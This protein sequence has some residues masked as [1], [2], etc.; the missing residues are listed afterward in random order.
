LII[1]DE[2][3]KPMKNIICCFAVL[4]SIVSCNQTTN[5]INSLNGRYVPF[6]VG[7]GYAHVLDTQTGRVYYQSGTYNDY[8]EG[9]IPK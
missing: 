2:T 5:P 8:V 3:I 1:I 7:E 6:Y 9:S 4:A